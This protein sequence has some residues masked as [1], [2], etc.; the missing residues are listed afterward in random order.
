MKLHGLAHRK[1]DLAFGIYVRAD[2]QLEVPLKYCRMQGAT[3]MKF[4]GEVLQQRYLTETLDELNFILDGCESWR[5]KSGCINQWLSEYW[6]HNWINDLNEQAGLAPSYEDVFEK[7]KELR[8]QRGLSNDKYTSQDTR[9]K[10]VHRYMQRWSALRTSI[11]THE[12]ENHTDIV[13]KAPCSHTPK[14]V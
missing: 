9:R 4:C 10:W 6:L 5:D 14:L 12:A 8:T 2:L 11:V 7:Y 3:D 1:W 13:R